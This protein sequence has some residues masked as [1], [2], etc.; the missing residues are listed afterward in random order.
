MSPYREAAERA[1]A[2]NA[3]KIAPLPRPWWVSHLVCTVLLLAGLYAELYREA[4]HFADWS[5]AGNITALVVFLAICV[6]RF[7]RA[8]PGA[9][10]NEP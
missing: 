7:A 10:W 9:P 2:Q 8:I 4:H 3:A 5:Q 1:I 6:V